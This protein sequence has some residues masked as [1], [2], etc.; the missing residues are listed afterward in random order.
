MTCTCVDELFT[1]AVIHRV[2]SKFAQKMSSIRNQ[3]RTAYFMVTKFSC[4]FTQSPS[5]FFVF[6]III[7]KCGILQTIIIERIFSSE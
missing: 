7:S 3:S 2:L 4:K 6:L 5:L 1:G